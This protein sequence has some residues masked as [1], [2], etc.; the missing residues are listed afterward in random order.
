MDN[1]VADLALAD[2]G[3]LRI[4]WAGDNRVFMTGPAEETF[5]GTLGSRLTSLLPESTPTKG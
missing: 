1:H 4:E 3:N 5:E 2:E